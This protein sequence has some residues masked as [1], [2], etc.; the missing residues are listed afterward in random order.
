MIQHSLLVLVLLTSTAIAQPG[1]TSPTEP[2]APTGVQNGD[3]RIETDLDA[4]IAKA[5]AAAP[6][7][8]TVARGAFRR[9]RRALSIGPTVGLWTAAI[10]DPGDVDAAL[11]I[12][13]GFETFKV[14]VLPS[15]ETLQDLI[16]ERVKAQMKQ[17]I[18]DTFKGR[19]PEPLELE[20][21]VKQV[22]EDV[23]NEILGLENVRPKTF[24]RPQFTLG[25]E[26]NRLFGADRWLARTRVGIG[27]W[28]VT[29][30]L[31]AAVGRV[32][33]GGTCDDGIKAFIGPEIVLHA[34]PSNQ[35]RA[36]VIDA[37]VRADFQ[38]N[39]RGVETYD[40]VVLGARYLLDVF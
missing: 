18:I 19:Q 9:A 26:A 21:F 3:A 12:G 31:S 34:L 36:S 10:V 17:R 40:Q 6:T 13:I 1:A 35:P 4:L 20:V 5:Q 22:Y 15:R 38:A 27:V 11:T 32:C 29:L 33:R 30:A 14:P 16:V 25:F 39:G 8:E 2:P 7:I 37:F 28:K 23:R 24:E